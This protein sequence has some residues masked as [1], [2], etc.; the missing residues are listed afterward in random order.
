VPTET[1]KFV[2]PVRFIDERHYEVFK[3]SD[4]QLDVEYKEMFRYQAL[5]DGQYDFDLLIPPTR[6]KMW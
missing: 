1:I 4:L 2:T 3:T 6:L 5:F